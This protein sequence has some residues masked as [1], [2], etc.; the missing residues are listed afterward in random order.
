MRKINWI[1]LHCADTE[2]GRDFTVFDIDRWHKQRGWAAVGYHFVITL[3]GTLQPGRV[4][5]SVGAHCLHHNADSIGIC[6]VGGRQRGM[7]CDTR[8]AAQRRTME[9]CVKDLLMRFPDAKVCGH[10]D[11]DGGK[12]C[13]CFDVATWAAEI[14]LPARNI[15]NKGKEVAA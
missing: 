12:A 4:V 10:H 2:A 15:Y 8:T 9:R 3:D 5:E 13:P 1:I 7:F 11:L 6:Y 14:G